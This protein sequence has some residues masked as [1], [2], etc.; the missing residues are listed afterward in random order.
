[1]LNKLLIFAQHFFSVVS[2][3]TTADMQ[4]GGGLGLALNIDSESFWVGVIVGLFF[5][6]VFTAIIALVKLVIKDIQESK[7]PDGK[8]EDL[9]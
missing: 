6:L 3:K 5:A 7:K 8:D 2:D 4:A 1:M 9:S